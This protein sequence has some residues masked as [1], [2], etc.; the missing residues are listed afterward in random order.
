MVSNRPVLVGG[1]QFDV[2]LSDTV[3]LHI[4]YM[5]YTYCILYTLWSYVYASVYM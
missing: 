4:I 1:G 5:L 2:E 3:Y